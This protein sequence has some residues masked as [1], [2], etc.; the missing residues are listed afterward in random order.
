VFT[1]G[2]PCLLP[3]YPAFL[4]FLVARRD[5]PA[6]SR[7]SALLGVVILVGILVT[8]TAAGI[9]VALLAIPL[10]SFLGVLVPAG[11]VL[12]IVL[13]LALIAGRSPFGR[14][15]GMAPS[16][17]GG[18]LRSAFA[19]G[20]ALAPMALPCS[21]AFLVALL[22]IAT[23]AVEAAGR[24]AIFVAFGFGFGLPLVLLSAAAAPVRTHLV[25]VI[26]GR[27]RTIDVIAGLVL[28]L[29]GALDLLSLPR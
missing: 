10:G 4:A 28:V 7:T 5:E 24:I 16:A 6:S 29:L 12:V 22:A 2:T 21:G 19:Y 25:A 27:A 8:M 14:L 9:V 17:T 3:L 23:G 1:A 15:P 26:R 13:G 18:P 11:D 20:M